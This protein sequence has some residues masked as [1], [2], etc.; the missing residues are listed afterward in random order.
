[1]AFTL[2]IMKITYNNK[3]IRRIHI[4]AISILVL[5]MVA[6]TLFI[7]QLKI[8]YFKWPLEY[9]ESTELYRTILASEG[10]NLYDGSTLPAGHSQ[11]GFSITLL[12]FYL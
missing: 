4:D 12:V 5:I 1:M 11:T 3:L 10:H 8:I 9:G 2:N 6:A 7:H